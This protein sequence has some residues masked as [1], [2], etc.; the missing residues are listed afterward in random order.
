MQTCV[1]LHNMLVSL[2]L[3]GELDDK[4]DDNGALL[5]PGQVVDEFF[6]APGVFESPGGDEGVIDSNSG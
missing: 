2:R 4:L 1:I 3:G 5:H 6:H